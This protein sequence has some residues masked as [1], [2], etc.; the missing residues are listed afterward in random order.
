VRRATATNWVSRLNI[1]TTSVEA[2]VQQLSGGNQQRVALA[3]WLA[4]DP[5]ILI[6]DLADRR[7]RHR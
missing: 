2:S 3:K 4:T 5:K 6:L 1:R 7:R